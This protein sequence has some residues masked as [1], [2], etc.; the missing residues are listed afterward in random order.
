MKLIKKFQAGGPMGSDT[1][2]QVDNGAMQ[3]GA[4]QDPMMQIVEMF[5]Q[6]LQSQ[7]C[8]LLAQG[9]EMFLSLVQEAQSSAEP[10]GQPV[11]GKGG[12]MVSRKQ[13][14]L[15]LICK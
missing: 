9:A 6:G 3:T 2:A 1:S 8:N 10:A 13:A 7:D 11:F 12:K 14:K 4:E 5:A 15:Q